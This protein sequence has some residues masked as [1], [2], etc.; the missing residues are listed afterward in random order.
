VRELPAAYR[1][2]DLDEGYAVQDRLCELIGGET[3]GWKVGATA[4]EVQEAFGVSEPVAGRLFRVRVHEYPATIPFDEFEAPPSF[5]CEICFVLGRDLAAQ[6]APFDRPTIVAA[7]DKVVP[8]VEV[9]SSRF[10]QMLAV[11]APSLV[12][13]NVAAGYLVTGEPVVASDAVDPREIAAALRVNG[14]LMAKGSGEAILGDPYAALQWLANHLAARGRGL[15]KGELISTG[16]LTGL[17]PAQPEDVAMADFGRL[18]R[19]S[20][21]LTG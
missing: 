9:I 15:R 16:T 14:E 7:V 21:H 20:V 5:E 19:V 10:E 18:G 6:D 3:A 17:C 12:A 11:D 2:A 4:P 8:A 13:D 1:P